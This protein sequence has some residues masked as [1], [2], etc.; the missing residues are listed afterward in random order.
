M[1]FLLSLLGVILLAVSLAGDITRLGDYE[2]RAPRAWEQFDPELANNVRSYDALLEHAA[3]TAGQPLENL[4]PEEAMAV[5]F[6]VV[7]ER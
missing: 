4:P 7:S 3:L 6:T 5:L 2:T 1:A